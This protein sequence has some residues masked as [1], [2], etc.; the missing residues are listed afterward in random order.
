VF[1]F[2]WVDKSETTFD[3]DTH[4]RVDESVFSLN[5]THA[6]G[7]FPAA[8]V[9]IINPR[10]G[11]LNNTRQ[12][13]AWISYKPKGSSVIHPLFFGRVLGVPQALQNNIIG[14]MLVARPQDYEAQREEVA[15]ELRVLPYF[16][17]V[18]L[19][20][21]ALNDPDAVLEGYSRLWHIDRVTHEVTTS[22]ILQDDDETPLVFSD[23]N[24]V[25]RDSVN[26]T[27]GQSPISRV[28]VTGRV[29]W[30]QSAAGTVDVTA[31]MLKAF[32][33]VTPVGMVTLSGMER[34][35]QGMINLIAGDDFFEKWPNKGDRVGS[36]WSIGDNWL[37]IVG[38]YPLPPTIMDNR[39][40]DVIHSG[41]WHQT[42]FANAWRIMF[43]RTPGLAMT[44][45]AFEDKTIGLENPV[46][47][48]RVTRVGKFDVMWVPI[49]RMAASLK[50]DY[51]VSRQ[52]S[53]TVTFDV[54]SDVQPLLADPSDEETLFLDCGSANVDVPIDG[55]I[56]LNTLRNN[57]YFAT[58]RGQRS[59][60]HLMARARALL[61]SRSR[62]VDI[63]FS[64]PFDEGL[65][66]SCRKTVTL[67][68]DRLPEGQATGKIKQYVLTVDGASGQARCS[69]VIGCAVGRGG[70]PVPQPGVPVYA[71]GY[72]DG[73]QDYIGGVIVPEV[74]DIS[75]ND[76][77]GYAIEDDGVDLIGLD[78]Q[79]A[80]LSLTVEGGLE[81][82]K[83]EAEK[84]TGG[85]STAV[86]VM[87]RIKSAKTT[88]TVQMVPLEAG[89]F[90]TELTVVTQPLHIPR[91]INLE[92]E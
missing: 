22:D 75:Y 16:D 2:A 9:Q 8:S 12:Q 88:L 57:R 19:S 65:G 72:M 28:V 17:P 91:M 64:M 53:E 25:F 47:G 82:E 38:G 86:E 13:W 23:D 73:Y 27:H 40:V 87:D 41:S 74:G 7:D 42:A 67:M 43:E 36:G 80:L 51:Q 63:T 78:T 46:N 70:S 55:V 62:A 4:A 77:R 18:W 26:V 31:P 84:T 30:G 76:Y 85:N 71:D 15:N 11:L 14:V 54:V 56:P 68:D 52:R 50:M 58:D 1:Y 3:P 10:V 45:L 5:I 29:E 39:I 61:I 90:D 59:M 79:S 6:E 92:A 20:G 35:T 44:V 69:V 48:G 24:D 66:L 89:P 49:F 21:D 83:E 33:D 60:E 37:D 34:T 81:K 32:R